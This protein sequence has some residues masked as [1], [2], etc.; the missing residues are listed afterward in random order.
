MVGLMSGRVM[1][2]C[3]LAGVERAG[4]V[5]ASGIEA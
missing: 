3:A 4:E 5:M 2:G 1:L